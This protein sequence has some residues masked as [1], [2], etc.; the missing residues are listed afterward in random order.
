VSVLTEGRPRTGDGTEEKLATMS[1]G[2][3]ATAAVAQMATPA[4][5][6]NEL[7]R[8]VFEELSTQGFGGRQVRA[9]VK[10][11][12]QLATAIA[13]VRGRNPDG[14]MTV[15]MTMTGHGLIAKVAPG[16]TRAQPDSLHGR[17]DDAYLPEGWHSVHDARGGCT[18]TGV[19]D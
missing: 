15:M 4:V 18:L 11:Y 8:A 17:L 9:V 12:Q 3:G 7:R 13:S 16:N 2:A 5:D 6:V 10:T 14:S 19:Q 1:G